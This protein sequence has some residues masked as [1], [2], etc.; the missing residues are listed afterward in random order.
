M[1]SCRSRVVAVVIALCIAFLDDGTAAAATKKKKRRSSRRARVAVVPPETPVGA[2]FEER[3]ASLINGPTS[4][5]SEASI[6]VVEIDSGRV[7]AER[8][9]H[10]PLSP[11]SNMKLFTTGA[12]VDLLKPT[13][14]ITTTVY[15][16]GSVDPSGTLDGDVKMVGRGDPTIG[17]RFHDG[18]ATAVIQEWATDLQRAGIKTVR[19]N[20]VFEYGYFDTEYIHPTWPVDQLVNWYEAPISAFS[21]QEGCVQVRVLPSRPGRTCVVQLEPPTEFL[22]VENKCVTGRGL[23]FITRPRNTNTIIVRGGVPSRSGPTEVFVSVEDPIHYFATVTAETFL[24]SRL[25]I[26]GHIVITPRDPRGDWR[27]VS[28]HTTPLNVIVYVVNKKSQNHYAEQLVKIIGAETRKNGSWDTGTTAISEWLTRKLGVP[29]D[30]FHQAD[31]SG[32]SRDNRASA[33]AFIH[34]LTYM[35]KSPWR[36]DFV[37]SLPYS[38]DPDAKFGKRL[39]RPPFARQVYA[40]TGYIVGVVGLSGYVHAQSGKIYAFS[41]LFNRYRVG[42]Y[43]VYNLQDEML[44][45][46]IRSG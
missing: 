36:E 13:F 8:N 23:P 44:K 3:L 21:M 40:K 24:R 34:V 5:A 19:G 20:L 41:F 42:V 12:A 46:I 16:R 33:S 43:A 22:D 26:E 27:A 38:G 4:R 37:S 7:V 30:E 39:R 2:T 25:K 14:E 17:G 28:Q 35:W 6:Q 18:Q 31:G 29:A 9:P 1:K 45:E 10:L 32:M 15:V 11:A